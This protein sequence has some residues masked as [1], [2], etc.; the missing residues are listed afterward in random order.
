METKDRM[1]TYEIGQE[2]P[3]RTVIAH[4]YAED[5]ANKMH[6]DEVAGQYG[7]QGGLVPGVGV[8]SYM[9]I[10][11]VDA[12]GN[13]WLESGHMTGK[14]IKPVY[15]EEPVLVSAKVTSIDPL[16]FA[17]T[18]TN[19][20]DTLCAVGEASLPESHPEVNLS[21]FPY[22][23]LPDPNKK[24]PP[25]LEALDEHVILGSLS[26]DIDLNDLRGESG[27]V[28]EELKDPLGIYRGEDPQCHPAYVVAQANQLL[29]SNV[30]LGPWIHTAS[31]VRHH[32]LPRHGETVNLQGYVAHSY[33]KRGHDIVVLNLAAVGEN[34]RV[35]QHL[36]HT[37][38]V[39]PHKES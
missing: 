29:V 37:A 24:F 2:L 9:T 21:Q 14:F 39:N 19:E 33:Q 6:S 36:T 38:I 11:I 5:S 30:N 15:H 35:L 3:A 34:D 23:P 12:L 22:V 7:F 31:D 26:Y 13:V 27:N 28:L 25:T 1:N 32:A 18:V 20:A 10:P 4:N 8:Y 17:I 16:R